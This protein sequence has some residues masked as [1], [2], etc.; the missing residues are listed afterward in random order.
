MTSCT[1]ATPRY[2][3]QGSDQRA[4]WASNFYTQRLT[5]ALQPKGQLLKQTSLRYLCEEQNNSYVLD[6]YINCFVVVLEENKVF[7]LLLH[8]KL[9]DVFNKAKVSSYEEARKIRFVQADCLSKKEYGFACLKLNWNST[10]R[11][12]LVEDKYAS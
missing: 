7:N 12:T 11:Q 5:T 6:N 2:K 9:H 3:G 4:G 8:G 1:R 10:Y